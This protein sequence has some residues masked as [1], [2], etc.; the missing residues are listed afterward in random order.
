M[1]PYL[2]Y[3]ELTS[4]NYMSSSP[5]DVT[6]KVEPPPNGNELVR[7]GFF[8][9]SIRIRYAGESLHVDVGEIQEQQTVAGEMGVNRMR[10]AL[11]R[12]DK[13]IVDAALET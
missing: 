4:E 12:N 1:R 5:P 2:T 10:V 8:T 9:V 6:S 7:Q 3:D 13:A 11:A